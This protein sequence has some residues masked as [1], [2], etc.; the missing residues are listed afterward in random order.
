[1][2]ISMILIFIFIYYMHKLIYKIIINGDYSK[3]NIGERIVANILEQIPGNKRIINDIMLND[4]GKSRQIDHIFISNKGVFVIETKN[5]SGS[6]YGKETSNEWIEYLNKKKYNFTNPIFQNY[7]HKQ[8][9]SKIINDY[10]NVI[11]IIVFTKSSKLKV[12]SPRNI[13]INTGQ[14]KSCILNQK[15]RLNDKKIDEYYN[16]I[17]N[18]R[19]TDEEIIRNHNYNVEHYI[20]YKNS[21][22]NK[23]I[24][25]RCKTGRLIVREGKYGKFIGCSNYPK[26]KY[27][28]NI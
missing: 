27:T 15:D 4:N 6:I 19:I 28:K 25:P 16:I 11:S 14:L 8:I 13:V 5:Y 12:K 3:G 2:I 9:V 21:L 17:M 1:M 10:N 23:N 18:N 26:C 20:E 22:I 7:A 24:C